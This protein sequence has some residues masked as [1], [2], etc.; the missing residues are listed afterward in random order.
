MQFSPQGHLSCC[1]GTPAP[2]CLHFCCSWSQPPAA[3][4]SIAQV[5]TSADSCLGP[6]KAITPLGFSACLLSK[7]TFCSLLSTYSL[8]LKFKTSTGRELDIFTYSPSSTQLYEVLAAGRPIRRW[9]AYRLVE[10]LF[11]DQW[12]QMR[13]AGHGRGEWQLLQEELCKSP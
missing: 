1:S 10:T 9:P 2:A 12:T 4:P 3:A 11:S 5:S 8:W 7:C 13:G 6:L